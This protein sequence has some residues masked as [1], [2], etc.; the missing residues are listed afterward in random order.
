M[1]NVRIALG[2]EY[3]GRGF[4]GWQIQ[5]GLPTLQG[6]LEAALQG[7]AGVPLA[8]TAAGRTDRGVHA[9]GQV[10]H[11]DVAVDRPLSAWVRGVNS[12][13]P[14]GMAVLWAQEV[15]PAFHARFSAK[16]R[17]YRYLL[18]EHPVRPALASGQVGWTHAPLD[19][20]AMR[21]G[22]QCLLGEHDFSS[23]RSSECQAESPVRV[24]RALDV[25]RIGGLVEFRFSANG[26]LHHMV[27]NL[28]G[29]LVAIGSHR[30]SPG[31][32]A[33]LLTLRDRTAAAPTFAPDGL[34]LS[35]IDYPQAFDLPTNGPHSLVLPHR[36]LEDS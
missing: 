29:C 4:A 35:Q 5:A 18:L 25:Q 7:I 14:P 31:W 13:L 24:L 22:M 32:M 23:W 20:D 26:F 30:Q 2:L 34:Y 10:V 33:E 11:F 15:P 12:G 28:V 6:A 9:L 21:Q 1:T 17:H 36:F 8:V 19:L 16:G 27:R 3:D